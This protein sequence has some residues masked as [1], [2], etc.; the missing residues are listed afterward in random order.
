MR[1][2]HEKYDSRVRTWGVGCP[3]ARISTDRPHG[4]ET[5][6]PGNKPQ[7]GQVPTQHSKYVMSI[8]LSHGLLQFDRSYVGLIF[9][10]I[11]IREQQG[12]CYNSLWSAHAQYTRTRNMLKYSS[13][14]R[15]K[16]VRHTLRG[17]S[18]GSKS[19]VCSTRSSV[20]F[21]D[22]VLPF[23]KP[24]IFTSVLFSTIQVGTRKVSFYLLIC[25]LFYD[26]SR[27]SFIPNTNLLRLYSAFYDTAPITE[28][29]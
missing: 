4:R 17:Q 25:G 21:N 28:T 13:S 22:F 1:N 23:T 15:R 10:R 14:I 3:S 2:T 12:H 26:T 16:E 20:C 9:T 8:H 7:T 29:N 6:R 18:Y 11:Y 27:H 5:H 24:E 19:L